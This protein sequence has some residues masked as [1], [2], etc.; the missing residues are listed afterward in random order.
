MKKQVYELEKFEVV[1]VL[2]S[3][4]LR[5]SELKKYK[6]IKKISLLL[7]MVESATFESLK[8]EG[9][10][11][12][13]SDR[14]MLNAGSVVECLVKSHFKGYDNLYKTFSDLKSDYQNGFLN[15]EVKASLP[16]ARNTALKERA[17]VILVNCLGAYL[18][19]KSVS[20]D[21][22]VDTQGR[23]YENVDYS[24]FEGVR[25]IGTLS[26]SLGL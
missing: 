14:K 19:K 16:N 11:G 6:E 7:S 4:L 18:I 3:E 26:K 10:R 21:L 13:T 20:M 2:E 22:L 23:Y 15:V 17:T 12:N 25:R 9:V 8:V 1:S 24:V 5:V